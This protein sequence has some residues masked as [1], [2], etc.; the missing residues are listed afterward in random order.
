M[1]ESIKLF[2]VTILIVFLLRMRCDLGLTMFLASLSLSILF[3]IGFKSLFY[4]AYLTII[5]PITLLLVGAVVFVYILSGIL[6]RTKNMEGIV[7]SLQY[8][9]ADHRLI[10]FLIASFLGLIPMVSGAMFSAPLVKEIGEKSRVKSEDMMLSN[11]WFRHVWEFIWPLIP[12]VALYA[13][14]LGISLSEMMVRQFPLTIIALGIGFFWMFLSIEKRNNHNKNLNDYKS[15]LLTFLQGVWPILLVLSL[16]LFLRVHL[17][18]ALSVSAIL[19]IIVHKLSL[20]TLLEII[21]YDIPLKVVTMIFGIMLFKQILNA[22]NSLG[23]VS[24]FLSDMG[25]NIWAI[26]FVI[27]FLL[28]LLTG[29]T[30]GF[31]GVSFPIVL[32]LITKNGSPNISMAMFAYLAGLSGMMLSPMHLCL[33]LTAEYFKVDLSK[34]YKKLFLN[35]FAL[36]IFGSIYIILFV[37]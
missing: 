14:M 1:T 5:D 31:V 12:G 29:I 26:L 17:L 34:L 9:I 11:Y 2:S 23:S 36:I 16:V 32:P 13:S 18:T 19:L 7:G 25:I 37:R 6:K 4:N 30:A 21:K 24:Q 28:G 15:H 3:K 33:A 35:V 20:K 22:T 27:P 8:L 10:L